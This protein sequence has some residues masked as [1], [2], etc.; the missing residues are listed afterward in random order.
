MEMSGL[1][2]LNTNIAA[3]MAR[4]AKERPRWLKMKRFPSAR[5]ATNAFNEPSRRRAGGRAMSSV[6]SIAAENKKL[7]A[8]SQKQAFSVSQ[9][10]SAPAS[11]GDSKR[12][13]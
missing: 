10:T 8:S 3:P 5:S 6:A 4:K 9:D 2:E 7:P 11:A 1:K 13:T 12:T